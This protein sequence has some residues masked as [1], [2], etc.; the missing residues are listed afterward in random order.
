MGSGETRGEAVSTGVEIAGRF[1][2]VHG[3]FALGWAV[4][5]GDPRRRITVEIVEGAEVVAIGEA[6]QPHEGLRKRNIGDGRYAFV[7]RLPA[8]IFDGEPHVLRARDAKTGIVLQG[9][10]VVAR[11]EA[12]HGEIEGVS[13]GV[14]F[15]WLPAN[16]N[17]KPPAVEL[18]VDGKVIGIAQASL[19]RPDI[20][21]NR[22]ADSAYGFCFD[23]SPHLE[24]GREHSIAVV[25]PATG[26]DI[27]G[28]PFSTAKRR[29]WGVLDTKGGIELG[30]WVVRTEPEEAPA[31]IEVELDG[32][33]IAEVRADRLRADLRRIGVPELRC[34]FSF[35]LPPRYYDRAAH[36]L[37]LRLKGTDVI[38]RGSKRKLRVDLRYA[39]DRV[40]EGGISGWILNAAAPEAPIR[41]DVWDDGEKIDT[42]L[43]DFPREDL[44]RE[45][46]GQQDGKLAAGFFIRLPEPKRGWKQRTV[47]LT[48]P[49]YVEPLTGKDIVLVPRH[50]LI[51]QAEEAARAGEALK[52]AMPAWIAELRKGYATSP[53]VHREVPVASPADAETPVDVIVPVFRGVEETLAC[54]RSVINT[55]DPLGFELVVI[56]DASPEPALTT[57][58]RKL[59]EHAGFTLIENPKNLGFVAT[60]NRGMK[61]H[62]GRDVILLNSDTVVPN[63]DWV[64]RLRRAAY[65][66]ENIA[67]VT[68]FSN[69]ATILSL[70]RNVHDNDLPAGW[71]V[72][73]LDAVCA[74]ENAGVAVPIP[75]A[76]GFCM[77]IKRA[78]LDEVGLFDEERWGRGYG[79]ENDFCLK[80]AA[81]GWKHVAACDVFVE[82]HGSVSFRG[83]KE[84][85]VRENLATLN[86][87][88]PDYP[89][90]VAEHLAADPL[91]APRAKVV[92]E[93]LRRRAPRYL[94]HVTHKWGGGI[95]VHVQDLA[96]RLAAEGEAALILRPADH[97][98]REVAT[99][100]GDLVLA[101]PAEAP[102]SAMVEDLKK[103][104]VW[105]VHFHQT[106]GL[107]EEVW[108]IPEQLGVQFDYTVHDY[109]LGCPRINLLDDN[110]RFCDQPEI[111]VCETCT[112]HA[113]LDAEVEEQ[114]RRVGSVAQWRAMH[115]RR[116]EA[117]RRVF[118]PSRDAAERFRK[119]F[120]SAPI[121]VMPHPEEPFEFA[122]KAIPPAG[123]LR[124]AVIGAIGPHKGHDLLLRVAK[125][126][127]M[128]GAPVRFVIVGYTCDDA[129]Y[130]TLDNVEILG[131]YEPEELPALLRSA[132]CHVALFLS[133]W[134]ETYSYTLS[135]AWRAG[136]APIV[137]ARGAPAERVRATGTGKVL[138]ENPAPQSILDAIEAIRGRN[139]RK[140][141]LRVVS[142]YDSLAGDYYGFG[143]S[144]RRGEARDL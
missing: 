88:Y 75:T 32:K 62:P 64:S 63:G 60:V 74:R 52:W 141:P 51:R 24:K 79:E 44:A 105:H 47:R 91:A 19:E 131:R 93:I 36:A 140:P 10:Q 4:G 22:I 108:D 13:A 69:R 99:P 138:P 95:D 90:R 78:A 39:I 106:I 18:R 61:L 46:F 34:G 20:V 57:A 115:A 6:N 135:E 81:M 37:R 67:T 33:V 82:H 143:T 89:R 76:I 126:A 48:P 72:D 70:P 83:E 5:V 84:A 27:A 30:G 142:S 38:L 7:I 121:A 94:L 40:D 87:L 49:G 97:G 17:G 3:E 9:E 68:P 8:S 111:D 120:K 130:R 59:A 15:G 139:I 12:A 117:A 25:D 29:G 96:R 1:E 136:L 119:F 92:V 144:S 123:E 28:S 100:E 114:F 73:E 56:N 26:R 104:S 45:L 16:A 85:R 54:V 109:Y 134:P 132:Q 86:H 80:S 77:Y 101:Y 133:P 98:W 112:A 21:E 65:A 127:K 102:L 53:V 50:E 55:R 43:A 110:G 107:G 124:V 66:A 129:A 23:L 137:T 125:L 122:P 118:A 11:R 103:L 31:V 41:M 14:V 2:A 42:V 113:P 116:L 128:S 35:V 71:S 58:L